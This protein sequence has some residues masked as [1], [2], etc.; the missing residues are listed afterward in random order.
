M[1][2]KLI[3]PC[4][5]SYAHVFEPR[6]MNEDSKKKYE[7]SLIISKSD[8]ETIRTVCKAIYEV[9]KSDKGVRDLGQPNVDRIKSNLE[10]AMKGDFSD[11]GKGKFMLAFKDGDEEH[12]E[13]PAYENSVFI[14]ARNQRKPGVVDKYGREITDP[15]EFYSGCYGLAHIEFFSYNKD[16][17]KGISASLENVMKK[18]EGERLSGDRIDPE[19]AFA[20]H[21]ED[22][23]DDFAADED[24]DDLDVL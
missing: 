20:G 13:D 22:A 21:F 11:L 15:D 12:P 5:F 9:A 2:Q 16:V 19:E 23:A 8:T 10:K 18:E 14:S 3:I 6:S 1:A 24:D 4:R 17:N 7:A